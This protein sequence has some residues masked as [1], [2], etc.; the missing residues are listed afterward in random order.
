[1]APK[2]TEQLLDL[3]VTAACWAQKQ[4]LQP[5]AAAG[6]GSDGSIGAGPSRALPQLPEVLPLHK[7]RRNGRL[8]AA[9]Q[10]SVPAVA[11]P[12]RPLALPLHLGSVVLPL[13]T[14]NE[15]KLKSVQVGGKR[16]ACASRGS[17]YCRGLPGGGVYGIS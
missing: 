7:L 17:A 12:E 14:L 1:M 4:A 2:L 10:E 8:F 6:G 16:N 3:N 11:R 13:A 15:E 5:G 9:L